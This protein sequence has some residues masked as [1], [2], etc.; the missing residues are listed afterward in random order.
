[1]DSYHD[2]AERR[3]QWRQALASSLMH[4]VT[5]IRA[6]EYT[7]GWRTKSEPVLLECEDG[8]DYVVKGQ[9]A[10]RQIVNDQLVARLGKLLDAP[11]GKPEIILIPQTLINNNPRYLE[12][13]RAGTAHGT[14]WIKDCRDSYT[15][16]ATGEAENRHRLVLLATLYGW[17]CASDRQFLFKENPPRLIYSVD[18]GHF[19]PNGPNWSSEDL[20]DTPLACLDTY[21]N[22]CYF[23][24]HEL[25][26]AC[27]KLKA[28]TEGQLIQTVSTIPITWGFTIEERL[29]MIVFLL[30]R[31]KE[32][33]RQVCPADTV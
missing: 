22:D 29:N 17:I 12:N 13:F 6:V 32:L 11:V 18:H 3:A 7:R 19:F 23:T 26:Y 5:S 10:G 8:N 20:A 27:Q 21:F 33:V 24:P 1:M 9:Q 15:L 14:L 16:I 31:Q 28:I 4:P 25:C 2:C 30:N